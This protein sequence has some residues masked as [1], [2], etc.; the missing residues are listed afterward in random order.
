MTTLRTPFEV[1]MQRLFDE[2][3]H[4]IE[5]GYLRSIGVMPPPTPEEFAKS[6][7]EMKAMRQHAARSLIQMGLDLFDEIGRTPVE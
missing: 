4:E 6:L 1:E 3:Q 7:D 2:F 5:L